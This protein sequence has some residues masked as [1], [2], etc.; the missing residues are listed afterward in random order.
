MELPA[1]MQHCSILCRVREILLDKV[2][3]M[4]SQESLSKVKDGS[5]CKY[6]EIFGS[7]K[8]GSM[9]CVWLRMIAATSSGGLK[10]K[11]PKGVNPIFRH[12]SVETPVVIILV[13][14]FPCLWRNE[15]HIKHTL[16]R[17]S[18]CRLSS[19][20]QKHGGNTNP[21]TPKPQ[22]HAPV[23][24]MSLN[25]NENYT[26]NTVYVLCRVPP[27][28]VLAKW[29]RRRVRQR[30]ARRVACWAEVVEDKPLIACVI[31]LLN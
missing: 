13:L 31:E 26:L 19:S 22:R 27:R 17:F 23:G 6:Y 20:T 15:M 28:R 10:I 1:F 8:Y 16:Q 21:S 25:W 2:C 5:D 12:R 9:Q 30:S 4:L 7:I 24:R 18:V 11:K 29:N 3:K 14:P